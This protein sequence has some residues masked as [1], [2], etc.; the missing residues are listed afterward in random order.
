MDGRRQIQELEVQ[1]AVTRHVQRK[2]G[3]PL[4]V[5][6]VCLAEVRRRQPPQQ[7]VLLGSAAQV[8]PPHDIQGQTHP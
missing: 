4:A 8:H 1:E 7:H 2:L 3:D 6:S 5:R